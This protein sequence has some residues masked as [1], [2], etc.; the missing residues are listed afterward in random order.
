MF[1]WWDDRIFYDQENFDWSDK[2][3][4]VT[5]YR[6]AQVSKDQTP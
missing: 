2:K 1:S 6:L 3:G 4:I 5:T